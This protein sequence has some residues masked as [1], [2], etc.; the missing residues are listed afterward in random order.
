MNVV[1]SKYEHIIGIVVNNKDIERNEDMTL[2]VLSAVEADSRVT[3]RSLSND[4]GIALGL[5]NAYLKKCID[6]GLVKIQQVPANRYAYYLTPRGFA[7]KT[8][9]TAKYFKTSFSFYRRAR[10]ECSNILKNLIDNEKF[11]LIL[12]DYSEFAEI[13]TIVA[14]NSN[15]QLLGILGTS[16][17]QTINIPIKKD[18][19][20]F[21]SYDKILITNMDDVN[22]RYSQL[23][24]I[25]SKDKIIIPNILNSN[26]SLEK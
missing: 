3:Q 12:S 2:S 18:I 1:C 9:L 21:G 16:T 15:I 17:G 6:K 5:T 7:E 23:V 19:K 25:A 11:K 8:R 20:S 26:I 13:V 22:L 4:L 10:N 24:K 14:L